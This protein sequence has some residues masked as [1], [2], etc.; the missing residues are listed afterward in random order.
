MTTAKQTWFNKW[1][2]TVIVVI[3]LFANFIAFTSYNS[4]ALGSYTQKA[5]QKISANEKR[6]CEQERS[7][8]Q[9]KNENKEYIILLTRVAT[10][11]EGVERNLNRLDKRVDDR[12]AEISAQIADIRKVVEQRIR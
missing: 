7:L 8:Q 1:L 11:L 10:R 6:V 5:E 12:T 2:S 4:Y 3:V 9:I